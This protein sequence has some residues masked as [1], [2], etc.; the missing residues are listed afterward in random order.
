[1]SDASEDARGE[2]EQPSSGWIEQRA[3]VARG[4]PVGFG[5]GVDQTELWQETAPL[6]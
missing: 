5:E 1:M 2:G 4:Y 3:A 6:A